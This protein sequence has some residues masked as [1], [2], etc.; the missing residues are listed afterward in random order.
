MKEQVKDTHL[1][2]PARLLRDIKKMAVT[3]RRTMTAEV[4][5][6]MENK[7]REW[8]SQGHRT[9]NVRPATGKEKQ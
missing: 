2:F 4:V 6:A 8:K 9:D 7:V 5:L 1:Y 3:N